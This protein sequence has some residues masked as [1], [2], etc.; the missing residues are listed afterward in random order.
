MI[1]T[2]QRDRKAGLKKLPLVK[3]DQNI[4]SKRLILTELSDL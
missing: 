2:C 4:D 3:F 1:G